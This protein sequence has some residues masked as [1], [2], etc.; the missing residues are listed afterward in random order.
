MLDSHNYA[1]VAQT[2]SVTVYG[3]GSL[4]NIVN[5]GTVS[6]AAGSVPR[7]ITLDRSDSFV[8]TANEGAGTI[9]GFGISGSGS[10]NEIS[11]SPMAG[12]PNVSALVADNTGDYMV[13]VGYDANT[14]IRLYS[15]AST[16]ALT[17]VAQTGSGANDAYPALVAMT[18]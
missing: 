4:S 8:Y 7:A 17:Q 2:S 12:P 13:A 15:I 16:G 5:E 11:G 9:S 3:I 14:G 18:H 6:Y 1:Y 10:L